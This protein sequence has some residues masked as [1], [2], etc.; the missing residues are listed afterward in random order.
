MIT[1]LRGLFSV[2]LKSHSFQL[3]NQTGRKQT[4]WLFTKCG[5]F[6]PGVIEDKFVQ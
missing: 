6:A 5:E 1:P 2:M 3:R 4:S